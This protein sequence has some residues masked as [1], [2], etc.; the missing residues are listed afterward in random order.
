[1]L[2]LQHADN[3]ERAP[4]RFQFV[5]DRWCCEA[6]YY[7]TVLPWLQEQGIRDAVPR[8]Q[9]LTLKLHDTRK[10][11]AFQ[12]QAL[13]A[14]KHARG[15][16]SIILPISAAKTLVAVHAI[17]AISSSTVIIVPTVQLLS[18]W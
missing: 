16:G 10:P 2:V 12:I 3:I 5:Q 8:W 1:M 14:W 4:V 13:E 11:H 7:H 17:H 18:Q 15:R 9:H 6:H